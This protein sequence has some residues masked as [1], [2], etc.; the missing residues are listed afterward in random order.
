MSERNWKVFI[1]DINTS[2]ERISEYTNG[3]N[4]EQLIKD[5]K[6]Y[7]AVLRNLEIIGEAV[8]NIPEDIKI[9]NKHIEWKKISGLRDIV[10]HDYFGLNNEIIWDVIANKIPELK[11]NLERLET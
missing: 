7:D 4:Y 8:K 9:R 2:I 10:I 6:T 5:Y 1:K 11:R 3:L